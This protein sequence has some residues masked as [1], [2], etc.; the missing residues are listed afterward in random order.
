MLAYNPNFV[1]LSLSQDL[2]ILLIFV[3]IN[4]ARNSIFK[5]LHS[6]TAV[7]CSYAYNIRC[8]VNQDRHKRLKRTTNSRSKTSNRRR[9]TCLI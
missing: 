4:Y 7:P 8:W 3:M 9:I 5:S 6:Y 2:I 1:T